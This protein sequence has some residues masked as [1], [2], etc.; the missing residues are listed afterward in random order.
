MEFFFFRFYER[1]CWSDVRLILFVRNGVLGWGYFCYLK[2]KLEYGIFEN[3]CFLGE[4]C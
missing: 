4:F 3:S 1:C 2:D